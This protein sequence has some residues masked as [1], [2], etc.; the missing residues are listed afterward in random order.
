MSSVALLPR[1]VLNRV[2][3]AFALITAVLVMTPVSQADD[4]YAS[5]VID[6]GSDQV[7]HDRFADSP[8][9]PASLTKVMTLYMV[10][11]A[12]DNGQ[13]TLEEELP[14]STRASQAAPSKLGLAPGSTIS[15]EDAILA[16][17]TKSANDVAIV[18][19]ERLGGSESRF[20]AL[21]T[22][23]ARAL[24]MQNTRFYNASGL[25]DT[26]QIS[27]ARDMATLAAHIME[28]HGDYYS[29]FQT[30]SFSWGGRTYGNHNNLL[31][32]V[33]GVDGIKTGYTRASGF[34]LMSTAERNGNRI[35][36]VVLG[37]A[38]SRARDAHVTELLEA[39]FQAIELTG[40][41]QPDLRT[42]IAFQ[43][44]Q[45]PD[46]TNLTALANTLQLEQG[47]TV[48]GGE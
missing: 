32:S 17:V 48:G 5:I 34:N 14:V 33:E 15:V 3:A 25:P 28:D 19:G 38:T 2:F 4:R 44:I 7:L 30:R 41:A 6:V 20:A 42:R 12:L 8:R 22:V 23:K 37:G 26:R 29:Y 11:D 39:A 21:M 27:T 36:T 35:I 31:G 46:E 16:L 9:Y 1:V 18:V 47:S 10:F 45:N 24:G 13:L 43:A 40:P